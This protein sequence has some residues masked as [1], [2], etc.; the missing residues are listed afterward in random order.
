M[1]TPLKNITFGSI[2][3]SNK[4]NIKINKN[5]HTPI[6]TSNLPNI[7]FGQYID[8][9]KPITFDREIEENW[10][11]LPTIPLEDGTKKQIMPDKS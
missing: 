3:K 9:K 7:N 11:K 1:I 6:N 5:H 10:F 2:K 8:I 4:Q